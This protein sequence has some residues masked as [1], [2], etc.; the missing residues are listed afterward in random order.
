MTWDP[1]WTPPEI[2]ASAGALLFNSAGELLIL[3]PTYKSGWTIPGGAM[4]SD[5]E[6]PWEA[7]QREV[8]EETGLTVTQG[9]LVIVDSRPA[10]ARTKLGL[11]FLF[12]CGTLSDAQIASIELQPSEISE[13]CFADRETAM[14]LLRKPVRRRVKRGWDAP[15]CRYLENGR[16]VDGIVNPSE[17]PAS[18]V[19]WG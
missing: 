13:F 11:R 17:H 15:A 10:K 8:A 12:H 6:T 1:H 7:C 4:E 19:L 9:R 18:G 5:G 14:E 16:E 3:K 2:P